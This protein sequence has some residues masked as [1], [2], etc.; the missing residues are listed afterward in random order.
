MQLPIGQENCRC[1]ARLPAIDPP[2][3]SPRPSLRRRR[4]CGRFPGGVQNC[5]AG[6]RPCAS[7]CRRTIWRCSLLRLSFETNHLASPPLGGDSHA[8]NRSVGVYNF[9]K[10]P[11][12]VARLTD[13]IPHRRACSS[14]RDTIRAIVRYRHCSRRCRCTCE[15]S[16]SLHFRDL[17]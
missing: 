14:P 8:L 1:R 12:A 7:R 13:H 17:S 9:R 2:A 11:R 6:A 16:T 15:K 3:P 4:A 10:L 5:P